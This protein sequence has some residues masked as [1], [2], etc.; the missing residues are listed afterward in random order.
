MQPSSITV[1]ATSGTYTLVSSA[2]N[3]LTGT[4]GLAKSGGG[5]LIL[6]GSNAFTGSTA[7][8]GGSLLVNGILSS[9]T[10]TV[11]GGLLGGSGTVGG[12]VQLAAGGTIAPGAAPG[13][14]GILTLG[15]LSGTGGT[16]AM[17][18]TG[19]GAGQSD[20]LVTGGTLNYSGN[21]LQISL[22]GT[23]ANGSSWDLFDFT[24]PSG[25]L[26]AISPM[27]ADSAYN[28]LAWG[29]S[30][31]SANSYDQRYGAGIWLSDWSTGGQRFTFNQAS[32]V[33]TVV[34][35]PS[36]FAMAGA[37]IAALAAMRWRR[38]S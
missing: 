26:A 11:S 37:G 21:T 19:T 17:N 6:S 2:G 28:G 15:S 32:G 4:T 36:T 10:T 7:V 13:G 29:L 12:A 33:L 14:T 27:V 8:T 35:E 16:F 18:I 38:S 9:T 30:G 20:Q 22:A 25:T 24:T 23:Y 34:P 5:T 1:S 3:L 31:T